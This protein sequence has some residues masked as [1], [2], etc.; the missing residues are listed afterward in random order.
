MTLSKFLLLIEVTNIYNLSFMI[1]KM[2]YTK[3][4]NN[5]NRYSNLIVV[6]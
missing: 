1:D 5:N 4:I 3:G 6:K 2:L